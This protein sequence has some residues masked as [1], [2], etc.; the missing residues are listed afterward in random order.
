MPVTRRRPPVWPRAESTPGAKGYTYAGRPSTP[1]HMPDELVVRGATLAALLLALCA[2]FVLG[3]AAWPTPP[4]T[5]PTYEDLDRN[6]EAHVGETVERAGT[7]VDTDPVIL[8]LTYD[9]GV[10]ETTAFRLELEGTPPVE[11]GDSVY[12]YGKLRPGR[13]VDVDAERTLVRSPWEIRYMYRVSAL[14]V[15]LV[16]ARFVNGW[17]FRP[18]RLAFAPRE[19]TLYRRLRGGDDA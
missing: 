4:D 1:R 17:R 14:A 18:R 15:L 3:G 16:V 6:Y 19:E 8:E 9:S 13:T 12:F 7:V 11:V 2:L 10:F 5:P